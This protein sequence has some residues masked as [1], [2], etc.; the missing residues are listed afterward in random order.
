MDTAEKQL[1]KLEKKSKVD[2]VKV[3]KYLSEL[4]NTD[5]PR[6]QGKALQ[7]NLK[8]LWRY[9]VGNF[10][11]VVDIVAGG[12]GKTRNIADSSSIT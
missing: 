10:R 2:Y 7:G 1:K 9:R 3:K 8:G 5:N 4:N 11:I 6:R 12:S